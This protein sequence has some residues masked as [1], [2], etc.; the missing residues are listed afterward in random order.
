MEKQ[1]VLVAED[2]RDL[3]ELYSYVLK[4]GGFEVVEATDGEET[5]ERLASERPSVLVTDIM[6]PKVSGVEVI[7]RVKSRAELRNLPVIAI[8]AQADYLAQAY[9]LGAAR[10]MRKPFN[11][12]YLLDAVFYELSKQKGH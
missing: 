10:V 12:Y 3:R 8:S 4:E 11:P 1:R 6:M 9:Q 5:L 7:E 2:D